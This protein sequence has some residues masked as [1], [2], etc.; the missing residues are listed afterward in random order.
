MSIK[1]VKCAMRINPA[2]ILCENCVVAR[3]QI[4][5]FHDGHIQNGGNNCF[6]PMADAGLSVGA[7]KTM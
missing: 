4:T 7:G 5:R 2:T 3:K 6:G 1:F